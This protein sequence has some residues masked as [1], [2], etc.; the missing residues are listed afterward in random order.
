MGLALGTAFLLS[1]LEQAVRSLVM[2][3]DLSFV[4]FLSET[5]DLHTS[6]LKLHVF[7]IF[8]LHFA[9]SLWTW[10]R[11]VSYNLATARML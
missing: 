1:R 7:L 3:D 9:L 10:M 5:S 8:L 11:V 2:T 4:L 6:L